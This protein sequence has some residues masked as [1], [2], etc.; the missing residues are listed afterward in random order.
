[1]LFSSTCAAYGAPVRTPID[2]SHPQAPINPYGRSKLMVENALADY[3]AAYGLR[4][5]ALRYF[6]AAGADAAGELG[7]RHE[8]ETHVIPLAIRGASQ[9]GYRFTIHG[10]D[11]DTPDG[12][13]VR[14]YVHVTDLA[15]AHELALR[16]MLAG[17]NSDVFNLGTGTGVSV[18]EIADAVG[19]VAGAPLARAI[20]PRRPGD[21]AILVA[22]YSKAARVLQWRPQHSDI[23]NIV[24]T[25]WRWHARDRRPA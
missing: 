21:P 4:Y 7:E 20:G 19:R 24:A 25:A 5:A 16:R 13:A 6:N 14:D 8:P 22:D 9:P 2:E 23:D 11:Y 17:A 1:M 3:A 12:T 10:G 15:S 18:A